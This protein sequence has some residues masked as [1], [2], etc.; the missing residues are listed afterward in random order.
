M[1]HI[2]ALSL[3]SLVFMTVGTHAATDVAAGKQLYD[4]NCKRCHGASAG[5]GAGMKL[6]G[7]A[8]YWSP[9]V[10]K[11]AVM[12]GVDDENRKMKALMPVWGK[13]GLTKPKGKIP[14]DDDLANI[15]S[16]L[17]T[18]GPKTAD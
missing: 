6:K 16:Y 14:T 5:G 2:L 11:R 17:Q 1:R 3:C 15:Q 7:D 13:T 9:D 8:A 10:F 12:T 4:D 18:L